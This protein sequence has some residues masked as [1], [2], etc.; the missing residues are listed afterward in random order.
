[1]TTETENGAN[2]TSDAPVPEPQPFFILYLPDPAYSIELDLLARW[3]HG[4][5]LP[6]YGQETSSTRP[7]CPQWWQHMSAV[8]HLHSLWLAW[9]ALTGAGAEA[10]G[11]AMW[12]RDFL[13]PIMNTLRA[14]DGP[15]AGCKAGAHRPKE[16]PPIEEFGAPL[17]LES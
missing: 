4:L 15:F 14:P 11:P 7:W 6:I 16:T 2:S 5:L 1:M 10:T 17:P 13:M 3:V 8:G 12:H 9:Q